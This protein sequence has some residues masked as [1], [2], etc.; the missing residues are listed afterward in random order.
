[1]AVKRLTHAIAAWGVVLLLW[2]PVV[3]VNEIDKTLHRLLAIIASAALAIIIIAV[4]TKAKTWEM[5]VAAAT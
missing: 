5:F 2:L 3:A 4:L 1:M